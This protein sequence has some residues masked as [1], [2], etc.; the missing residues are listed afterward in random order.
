MNWNWPERLP[1][2]KYAGPGMVC[3]KSMK[4]MITDLISE[5]PGNLLV[6]VLKTH[7]KDLYDLLENTNITDTLIW[8]GPSDFVSFRKDIERFADAVSEHKQFFFTIIHPETNAIIGA[9]DIRPNEE[10]FK[11]SVGL[12]IG[13]PYQNCG[14]G[15]RVIRELLN[16]GFHEL[17]LQ[18]IEA[19]IFLSNPMSR[20]IFEKAGFQ[21]EGILHS[22]QLKKGRYIDE[23]IFGI[24]VDAY[25]NRRKNSRSNR[26]LDSLIVDHLKSMQGN[27]LTSL[28]L[29]TFAERSR[30]TNP[31]KVLEEWE[32]G[33]FFRLAMTDIH[34]LRKTQSIIENISLQAG[35][36]YVDLPPVAPFGSVSAVA[37]VS[38][39]NILSSIRGTEVVSDTTNILA[40]QAASIRK[41]NRNHKDSGMHTIRFSNSHRL[42][43]A[44]PLPGP[45]YYAYFDIF[46]MISAH[47]RSGE[48]SPET[49]LVKHIRIYIDA[50]RQMLDDPRILVH[51]YGNN[52]DHDILG[53]GSWISEGVSIDYSK[54][55][56]SG[57]NYY[58]SR[59]FHINLLV[60]GEETN[61]ADGGEVDWL[62]KYLSDKKQGLII[63]GMGLSRL[64]DLM[65][66]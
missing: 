39:N 22:S 45:G 13:I 54:E 57:N 23:W 49:E 38:Q 63:S 7:A 8:D 26:N 46:S 37:P 55:R 35:F 1:S 53:S 32:N 30:S 19:E 5:N 11:A 33:R 10:F 59:S 64:M 18:R 25:L 60:D 34:S 52:M 4:F 44:Q 50:I 27:R 9:A 16:F 36:E 21:L 43:R 47:Y 51:F 66:S 58:Q 28:L 15:T 48:D 3:K 29:D 17:S 65:S 56:P 42:V 14:F 31:G 6:P 40:L 61:L 20:R 41:K 12:W 2:R 24:T 62:E